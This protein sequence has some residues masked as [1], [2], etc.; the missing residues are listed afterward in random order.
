M[1]VPDAEVRRSIQAM[2]DNALAS[3][4]RLGHHAAVL[5]GDRLWDLLDD[6]RYMRDV[7]GDPVLFVRQ[8]A[9]WPARLDEDHPWRLTFTLGKKVKVLWDAPGLTPEQ[10]EVLVTLVETTPLPAAVEAARLLG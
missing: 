3:Y 8:E 4:T 9:E 2:L 7:D 5:V 6:H 10:D 1:K